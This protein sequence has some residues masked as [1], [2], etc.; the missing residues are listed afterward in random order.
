MR[1]LALWILGCLSAGILV[2][3]EPERPTSPISGDAASSRAETPPRQVLILRDE[4]AL[5]GQVR[6]L[7]NSY[8][9]RTASGTS[10]I[11]AAR[12]LRHCESLHEAYSFLRSRPLPDALQDALRLA[13]WCARHGL[14][15]EAR[16]EALR[17][18]QLR[19]DHREARR[20][21]GLLDGEP[22]AVSSPDVP[23]LPSA[24]PSREER[25]PPPKSLPSATRPTTA[26]PGEPTE[27]RYTPETLRSFAQRVQP[28]LFNSCATAACHGGNRGLAFELQRPPSTGVV[29]PVT[30]RN[31]LLQTLRFLDPDDPANSELLRKALEAHGGRPRPPLAGKDMPAYQTLEAWVLSVHPPRQP[32]PLDGEIGEPGAPPPV[33]LPASEP[34][35]PISET[36]PGSRSRSAAERFAADQVEASSAGTSEA[37]L[38]PAAASVGQSSSVGPDPYDPAP[39]NARFHPK[40]SQ[41]AKQ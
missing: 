1:A 8:E 22:P 41:P 21:A 27:H 28:I 11:P 40:R 29:Q 24:A 30:T 25:Q 37:V 5:V 15:E 36:V 26:K 7:D 14:V 33:S 13:R 20:L 19:P 12:V 31:N 16:Q 4:T 2:A 10:L 9:V 3:S 39:F 17:A 34:G 32:P 23:N 38:S 6:R 35:L 18:L